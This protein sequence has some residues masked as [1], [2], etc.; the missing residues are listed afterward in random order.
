MVVKKLLFGPHVTAM[1]Y[2]LFV[3]GPYM[4]ANLRCL[5]Y[6][7]YH[8]MWGGC[9]AVVRGSLRTH[10]VNGSIAPVANQAIH[11]SGV[12]KLVPDKSGRMKH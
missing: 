3:L 12:G 2:Q 6:I 1:F 4:V 5:R 7:T 8:T 10:T 11:P 9:G